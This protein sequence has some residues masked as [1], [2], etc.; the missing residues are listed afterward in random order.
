MRISG[1]RRGADL[2]LAVDD[3]GPGVAD[4][5]RK[6]V[7]LRGR[8][9]DESKSGAG[10]G[11]AIVSDLAELYRG[12]LELTHSDLGGLCAVLDLPAAAATAGSG[13]AVEPPMPVRR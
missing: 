5:D 6:A 2:H 3:D 1:H 4:H 8:R 12:S 11:L 13:R 9:L 7:L 10:L